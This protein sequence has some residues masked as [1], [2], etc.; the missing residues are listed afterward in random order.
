MYSLRYLCTYH[1]GTRNIQCS[2]CD[3]VKYESNPIFEC[4]DGKAS[5]F[6]LFLTIIT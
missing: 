6:L 4:N 2:E 5:S 1:H 3:I